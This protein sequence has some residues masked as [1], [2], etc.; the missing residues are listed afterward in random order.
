MQ[1]LSNY[2]PEWNI[3]YFGSSLDSAW[4]LVGPEGTHYPQL[5]WELGGE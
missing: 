1:S 3:R 2:R 4:I 5:S